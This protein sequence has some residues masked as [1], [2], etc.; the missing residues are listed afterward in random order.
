M[1]RAALIGLLLLTAACREQV[2][3]TPAL[4]GPELVDQQR[5]S[6]E[7]AHGRLG[8]GGKAG[9]LTCYMD[10]KDNG[11]QCT[12]AG[13]CEGDCLARSG[14]CAPVTPLFGCNEI[15]AENGARMT[16]CVD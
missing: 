11:K 3:D 7:K 5:A 4:I 6:C 16:Q 1:K 9:V 13:D 2:A 8:Q 10:T 14:T 12:K 15:L